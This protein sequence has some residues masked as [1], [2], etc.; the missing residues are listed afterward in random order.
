MNQ[1]DLRDIAPLETE[2]WVDATTAVAKNAGGSRAHYLID[3]V[4]E[5]L[6]RIGNTYEPPGN[7]PYKNTISPDRQHLMPGITKYRSIRAPE[8]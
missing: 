6:S 3:K 4:I 8:F 2:E 1:I 5:Q 7:T